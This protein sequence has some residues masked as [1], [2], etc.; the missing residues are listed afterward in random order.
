MKLMLVRSGEKC[1]INT[2]VLVMDMCCSFQKKNIEVCQSIMHYFFQGNKVRVFVIV[3]N[4]CNIQMYKVENII[5]RL[6][7]LSA[8]TITIT[9]F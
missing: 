6:S 9:L 2:F 4:T 8:L 1:T 3:E 5:W 7:M